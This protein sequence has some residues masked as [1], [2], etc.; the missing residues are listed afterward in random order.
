MYIQ[1]FDFEV[2]HILE[3]KHIAADRLSRRPRTESDDINNK[4]K[5][6]IKDFINAELDILLVALIYT[7]N[8][9]EDLDDSASNVLKNEYSEDLLKI[10]LYLT[11]LQC[12]D[13]IHQYEFKAFKQ[14][15]LNYTM[16]NRQL[17]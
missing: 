12:P 8:T 13:R 2:Q 4:N 14:R 5:E 6:D 7:N 3:K 1:L 17:F 16:I 9:S 10:A 11:T 15:A